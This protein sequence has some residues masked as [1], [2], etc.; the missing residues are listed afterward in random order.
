MEFFRG[1][2]LLSITT[3]KEVKRGVVHSFSFTPF[4][5]WCALRVSWVFSTEDVVPW[6][7]RWVHM[8]LVSLIGK[9]SRQQQLLW[10]YCCCC[11]GRLHAL[12]EGNDQ[13][14]FNRINPDECE[15]Q[16]LV[17]YWVL[18]CYPEPYATYQRPWKHRSSS[19]WC[20][21]WSREAQ[22][23]PY[24]CTKRR[25]SVV[26]KPAL[27]S[28]SEPSIK[29]VLAL[30]RVVLAPLSSAGVVGG[31][32]PALLGAPHCIY[33]KKITWYL[34]NVERKTHGSPTS[35]NNAIVVHIY[36]PGSIIRRRHM[37]L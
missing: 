31:H 2:L 3:R 17:Q 33:K 27:L 16:L 22:A 36:I 18:F 4:G 19:V 20:A 25:S 29:P 6:K 9:V 21:R 37:I 14:I 10:P 11:D 5:W 8:W 34:P 1:R 32:L 26:P 35:M 13:R 12:R 28:D 7:L 24:S 30:F 15:Q 23:L